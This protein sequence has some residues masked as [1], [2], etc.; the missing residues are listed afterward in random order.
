M[1]WYDPG[2]L[3]SL[4]GLL[5]FKLFGWIPLY[6]VLPFAALGIWMVCSK[7]QEDN[8]LSERQPNFYRNLPK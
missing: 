3:G 4:L 1:N 7:I 6:L 5:A 2:Y 8:Q